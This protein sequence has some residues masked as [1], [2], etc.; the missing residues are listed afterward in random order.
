MTTT[1]PGP[2]PGPPPHHHYGQ[3]PARRLRGPARHGRLGLASVA[4]LQH[5]R[6]LGLA[7]LVVGDLAPAALPL[8]FVP[9]LLTAFAFRPLNPD[10]RPPHHLRLEHPRFGPAG[11]SGVAGR[12]SS[13][14]SPPCTRSPRS[15][16]RRSWAGRARTRR[17][18]ALAVTCRRR[19][20]ARAGCHGRRSRRS[21]RRPSAVCDVGLQL[22]ALLAS[23]SRRSPTTARR[24]LPE[25][26]QPLR[27]RQLRRLRRGGAALPVHLLGLGRAD[28]LQRGNGRRRTHPRQGRRDL[29]RAP[30]RHLPV[31]RLRRPLLRRHRHH[32]PRTRRRGDRR[33]R[34]RQPRA[35][36]T[37]RPPGEVRP[38]RHRCLR[39]RRPADL[40]RLHPAHHLVDE[41]ARRPARRL[42]AH[43]PALPDSC[44]RHGLLRYR[45]GRRPVPAQRWSPPTSSATPSSPSAC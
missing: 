8:G 3:G 14:P 2:N 1:T 6:H 15:G 18:T 27:V 7:T 34:P 13:R 31:H 10:A 21:A 40:H 37:R 42:R 19:A 25:L 9:I 43:P 28:H 11:W 35:R 24:P 30:R 39:G 22:V 44:L 32:R 36:G 41:R 23:A 29:H 12:S 17:R 4:P 33:R 20:A 38:A 45:R 26:A 16:P 5:R